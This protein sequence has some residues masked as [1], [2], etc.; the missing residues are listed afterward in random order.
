M[1]NHAAGDGDMLDIWEVQASRASAAALTNG[2][3]L[4][5]RNSWWTGP[6]WFLE[7]TDTQAELGSI[8]S[9]GMSIWLF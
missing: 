4:G 8:W 5:H 9:R 2:G 3:P 1:T 7:T 6:T